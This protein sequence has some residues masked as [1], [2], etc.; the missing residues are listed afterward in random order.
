MYMLIGEDGGVLPQ[1]TLVVFYI[2]LHI[3]TLWMLALETSVWYNYKYVIVM[4]YYM[5]SHI[6]R[7][8]GSGYPVPGHMTDNHPITR[9]M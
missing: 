9:P 8:T 2:G 7:Y 1:K 6:V 4:S 3:K 5:H